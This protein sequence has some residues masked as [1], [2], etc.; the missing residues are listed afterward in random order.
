MPKEKHEKASMLDNIILKRIFKKGTLMKRIIF[1]LSVALTLTALCGTLSARERFY[2]KEPTN[3]KHD[4]GMQQPGF[5]DVL[6]TLV[7]KNKK[8]GL[9]SSQNQKDIYWLPKEAV[10]SEKILR[11]CKIGQVCRI[12]GDFKQVKI[13]RLTS[14]QKEYAFYKIHTAERE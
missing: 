2:K 7:V 10:G 8:L 9:I 4:L 6:G 13:K 5:F 12:G 3:P 14:T 1:L 11:R